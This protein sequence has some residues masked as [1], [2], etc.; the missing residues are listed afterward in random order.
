[1]PPLSFYDTPDLL[2]VLIG[3]S[4]PLSKSGNKGRKRS[5]KGLGYKFIQLRLLDLV[6]G[7]QG[8]NDLVFHLQYTSFFQ[9]L[10]NGVGRRLL[11]TQPFL[12]Q[13]HKLRTAVL[14]PT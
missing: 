8:G 14:S 6:L 10:H 7:E 12:A 5:F 1:M 13:T 2:D 4:L 11:P 3:Q 9:P